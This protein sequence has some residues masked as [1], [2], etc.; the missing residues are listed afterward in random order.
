MLT[1]GTLEEGLRAAG[2]QGGT[3]RALSMSRT[4]RRCRR[5]AS[6]ARN[7]I[8]SD[9]GADATA[10]PDFVQLE[11]RKW[12]TAEHQHTH[13]PNADSGRS[14][15][16]TYPTE[17]VCSTPGAAGHAGKGHE[18][19]LPGTTILFPSPISCPVRFAGI[20]EPDAYC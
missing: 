10:L 15:H 19:A 7:S 20:L 2:L 13:S 9:N 4:A 18:P 8:L 16:V 1:A 6:C 14:A 17:P 12:G 5:M 11:N 3:S